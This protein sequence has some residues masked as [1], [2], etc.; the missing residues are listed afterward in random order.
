MQRFFIRG[1][2]AGELPRIQREQLATVGA[3]LREVYRAPFRA[4]AEEVRTHTVAEQENHRRAAILRMILFT[5]A[6]LVG[7]IAVPMAL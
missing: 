6:V 4:D 1:P 5:T 7:G 2:G 3:Y